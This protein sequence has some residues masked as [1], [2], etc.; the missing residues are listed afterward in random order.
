MV[1]WRRNEITKDLR[2]DRLSERQEEVRLLIVRGYN[3]YEIAAALGVSVTV[4]KGDMR[5]IKHIRPLPKGFG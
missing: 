5:A 2:I 4:V 3:K 1:K